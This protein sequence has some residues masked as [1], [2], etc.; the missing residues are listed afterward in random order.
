MNTPNNEYPLPLSH[1]DVKTN[2]I[3]VS[4]PPEPMQEMNVLS[5]TLLSPQKCD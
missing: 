5:H 2:A 1:E 4:H 3:C